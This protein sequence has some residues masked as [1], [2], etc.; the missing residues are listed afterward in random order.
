MAP[1]CAQR[2]SNFFPCAIASPI[3]RS[4]VRFA[5]VALEHL[6]DA[7]LREPGPVQVVEGSGEMKEAARK[8]T[9]TLRL[10]EA[11]QLFGRIWGIAARPVRSEAERQDPAR[12]GARHVVE[13]VG[14][15]MSGS[16]LQ[17][18]QER[19]GNHPPDAAAVDGKHTDHRHE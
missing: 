2:S 10:V 19:G 5:E 16:L 7:V 18:V 3:L 4:A 14:Y 9:A 13:Q 8:D 11:H 1:S 12:R 15:A 17:A 6:V